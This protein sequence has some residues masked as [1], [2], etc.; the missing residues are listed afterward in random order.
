MPKKYDSVFQ[1]KITLRDIKPP[2]WRRIQV[3]EY[4]TFWNLHVAIQNATGWNDSHMHHF[5]VNS[6]EKDGVIR[7]G[8]PNPED[9]NRGRK[10]IT[11]PERGQ[12]LSDYYLKGYKRM[13]Y[14]Y[15]YG[16]DWRH[17]VVFE[18]VLDREDGKSYPICRAGERACPPEDSGGVFVYQDMLKAIANKNHAEHENIMSWLGEKFDPESFDPAR[19]HF[20][21]V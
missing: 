13:E 3:P 20:S 19:V 21:D 2:I 7:I 9:R 12:K 8:T 15:D 6:I 17:E 16:D 14:L 10:K 5:E 18:N 1:F 4:Y 11:L